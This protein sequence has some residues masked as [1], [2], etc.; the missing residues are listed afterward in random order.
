MPEINDI[1]AG[2]AEHYNNLHRFLNSGLIDP[3]KV[4]FVRMEIATIE[5]EI[6][7]KP[8]P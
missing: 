4:D 5:R 6:G 3:L 7:I 2:V 1:P 8:Q